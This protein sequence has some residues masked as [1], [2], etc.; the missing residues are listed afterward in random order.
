MAKIEVFIS[1]ILVKIIYYIT[2]FFPVNKNKIVIN[3]YFNNDLG[4][5]YSRLY[6][7]LDKE[8]YIVKCILVKFKGN[9]L[10]KLKYLFGLFYQTYLFNTSKVILLDGNNFVYSTINVKKQVKVIQLWHATG[11][12]KNFGNLTKRRYQIKGYDS[13][14]VSSDFFK[15]I[16]SRALNTEINNI[17]P[18]G[19]TKTDYLFD[20]EFINDRKELFYQKNPHLIEKKIILYA[21]TFRGDGVDDARVDSDIGELTD[22]LSEEYHLIASLHPLSKEYNLKD[23]NK[24]IDM[25]KEDLYTLLCVSDIIISDY[26][27]LIF[28]ASLLNKKIIMYLYDLDTYTETRG[29]CLNIDEMPLTKCFNIEE[30]YHSII[31]AE[32]NIDNSDFINKYVSALDGNSTDRIFLHIKDMMN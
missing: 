15:D 18:L 8:G 11:A 22:Y 21:P 12:I 6:D 29:L 32:K 1:T 20:D 13:L 9:A 19:I 5:E 14:I 3:S 17:H 31:T 2:Y 28:D 10:G 27:A 25:Q 16:F 7:L 26:S 30:L 4:L 23:I 24:K